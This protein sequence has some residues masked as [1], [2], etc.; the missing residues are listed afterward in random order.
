M[1]DWLSGRAP[2]SHRGGHWFDPS[3]AHEPAY[4]GRWPLATFRV[5]RSVFP[6]A[7]A[8]GTPTARVA[9][10]GG[11]RLPSAGRS[12][13]PGAEPPAYAVAIG[14]R[15]P[16]VP[17]AACYRGAA[18]SGCMFRSASPHAAIASSTE[19]KLWPRSVSA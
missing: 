7:R 8:P 10:V 15:E 13:F 9:L 2:R 11:F 5:G 19:R 6:G 4:A 12:A 1:G 17:P 18:T 3:I 14:G 16:A